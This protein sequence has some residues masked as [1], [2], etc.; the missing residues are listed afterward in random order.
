MGASRKNSETDRKYL[1]E[2]NSLK[3]NHFVYFKSLFN[4]KAEVSVK[5]QT[6]QYEIEKAHEF[7][8]K[9]FE[10]NVIPAVHV[11]PIELF[12]DI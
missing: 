3:T 6:F 8:A 1:I 7:I 2:H 12:L 9:S 4:L 11:L 5:F 10:L